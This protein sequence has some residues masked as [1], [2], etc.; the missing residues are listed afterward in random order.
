MQ[1]LL[2]SQL[3]KETQINRATTPV[4]VFSTHNPDE[5]TI[6]KLTERHN[7][8][9]HLPNKIKN[10]LASV[11]ISK[12]IQAIGQKY[13]FD[14]LRLANI[15][16]LIREYYFGEARIENF[17]K[18]IEK[19]MGVSLFTAQEIARYV[20][21][22]IIDWDPW[23]KYIAGLPKMPIREVLVK[24]PDVGD[25][26]VTENEIRI[27][28]FPEPVRPSI[29]NWLHDY[30][31]HLGQDKHSS[32]QRT[33]FLFHSEN[34]GRLSSPDREKLSIILKS[35]DDN[36]V[37]SIDA[38][39]K[40]VLFDITEKKPEVPASFP[41][42]GIAPKRPEIAPAFP[43][44]QRSPSHISSPNFTKPYPQVSPP[45]P[46]PA[47]PP[48]EIK[49]YSPPIPPRQMPPAPQIFSRPSQ[50]QL[51]Q[52]GPPG[53]PLQKT[54]PPQM[55]YDYTRPISQAMKPIPPGEVQ[56]SNPYPDPGTHE[57]HFS[58][59]EKNITNV[60]FAEGVSKEDPA[61]TFPAY[62]Q[63][64]PMPTRPKNVIRPHTSEEAR[65]FAADPRIS[66]NLV[67]LSEKTE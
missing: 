37:L 62:A 55:K 67:D 27:K 22:Q 51:Q 24:I 28:N 31:Q 34:T 36:E 25:Q 44:G 10:K 9:L 26:L 21:S 48:I 30:T 45:K 5:E 19:R 38:E 32:M 66:G 49:S 39:K 15:T 16:R 61:K 53:K 43:S 54:A 64:P 11:E 3:N 52:A 29:R 63:K 18:E 65:F 50:Q 33:E 35:F 41:A 60:R 40:E 57:T 1:R 56:F 6:E 20:K 23:A 47:I 12:K 13:S 59:P 2:F 7:K 46:A 4:L 17:P 14:L 8:F 42:G 58:S